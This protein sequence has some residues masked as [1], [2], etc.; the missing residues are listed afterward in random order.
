MVCHRQF[1]DTYIRTYSGECF[2][3]QVSN[4]TC[5]HASQTLKCSDV[6]DDMTIEVSNNT[7]MHVPHRLLNVQMF[8]YI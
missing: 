2:P 3:I 1:S 4:N 5:R 6:S 7:R 8:E